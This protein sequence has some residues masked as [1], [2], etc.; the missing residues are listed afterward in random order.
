MILRSLTLAANVYQLR[1][2][3]LCKT[4]L[5]PLYSC[6]LIVY[7]FILWLLQ[8]HTTH[9]HGWRVILLLVNVDSNSWTAHWWSLIEAEVIPR[10]ESLPGCQLLIIATLNQFF[11][12]KSLAGKPLMKW[13]HQRS[14]RCPF[15]P[16]CC[17]THVNS[18][19]LWIKQVV[20]SAAWNTWT[21]MPGLLRQGEPMAWI[22]ISDQ[23]SICTWRPEG[24]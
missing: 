3:S 2:S 19:F 18:K 15:L 23:C 4:L 24:R 11:S 21:C 8:L 7:F 20:H 22:L 10:E 13:L 16:S 1:L 6:V 17:E 12:F 9:L 5:P 14:K